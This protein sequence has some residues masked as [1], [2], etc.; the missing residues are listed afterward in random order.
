MNCHVNPDALTHDLSD[1]LPTEDANC[2]S[3]AIAEEILLLE[4]CLDGLSE[5]RLAKSC[6]LAWLDSAERHIYDKLDARRLQLSF[7]HPTSLRGAIACLD[8]AYRFTESAQSTE[9]PSM[10][11]ERA[12][13]RCHFA[14]V[15]FLSQVPGSVVHKD[16]LRLDPFRYL[17]LA[18][19][20]AD[21]VALIEREV[22]VKRVEIHGPVLAACD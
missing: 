3:A 1:D 13:K 14:A 11:D 7:S 21:I 9:E 22:P 20:A 10:A 17:D 2:P 4:D 5:A 8:Q 19:S 6:N 16:T 18:E 12:S 15:R